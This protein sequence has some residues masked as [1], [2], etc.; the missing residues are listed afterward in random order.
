MVSDIF[1]LTMTVYQANVFAGIVPKINC[2]S[3]LSILSVPDE[4]HSIQKYVVRTKC[5]IFTFLMIT[6]HHSIN[7]FKI[8][9]V[10][11]VGKGGRG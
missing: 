1:A 9:M 11:F 6:N 3:N 7:N 8:P 2:L 10:L 4:C 5:F